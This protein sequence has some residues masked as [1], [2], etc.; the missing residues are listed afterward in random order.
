ME[1]VYKHWL[2]AAAT[3]LAYQWKLLETWYQVGPAIVE[4]ALGT[5]ATTAKPTQEIAGPSPALELEK[6]ENLAFERVS[7]GLAPPREIYQVPYRNKIDWGRFPDWAK[8]SDPELFEG[9]SH[10][11]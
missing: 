1:M 8:P 3:L 7:K 6:L 9:S 4:A 5:S 11:G 10:E 2:N